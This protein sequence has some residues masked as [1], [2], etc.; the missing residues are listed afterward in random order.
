MSVHYR[1]SSTQFLLMKKILQTIVLA[2]FVAVS[3]GFTSPVRNGLEASFGVSESDPSQITLSLHEDF[4][5]EYQDLS[6]IQQK[7]IVEGTYELK[8]NRIS[9]AATTSTTS[10]HDTWKISEDGTAARSRK[11]LAFYTL[12]RQ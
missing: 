1:N 12:R 8:N 5:F 6:D 3:F 2:L 9:L 4:T 10:F 7:I 11:G